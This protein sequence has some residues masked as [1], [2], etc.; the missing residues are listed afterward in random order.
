MRSKNELPQKVA[1]QLRGEKKK[2]LDRMLEQ[3]KSVTV[4]FLEYDWSSNDVNFHVFQ[5]RDLSS[6]STFPYPSN[7]PALRYEVMQ[8]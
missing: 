4:K 5:K 3:G 7:P 6:K 1:Q 2:T 8:D